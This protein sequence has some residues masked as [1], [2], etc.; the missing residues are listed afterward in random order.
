ML[1]KGLESMARLPE[2]IIRQTIK[3]HLSK[4]DELNRAIRKKS[5]E[6]EKTDG[7]L[8]RLIEQR[9][10]HQEEANKANRSQS[11]SQTS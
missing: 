9:D 1:T 5:K 3:F 11:P 8:Q 4:I 7:E 2:S 10:Q 6:R